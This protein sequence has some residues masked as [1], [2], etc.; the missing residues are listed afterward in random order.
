M[1]IAALF[2]ATTAMV[3]TTFASCSA[4]ESK[5]NAVKTLF[6]VG[7]AKFHDPVELPVILKTYLENNGSYDIDIT[8]DHNEFLPEKIKNYKL[9]IVYTT[10]G[11]LTAEQQMG[12]TEWVKQGNGFIGIHSAT[13]SFKN[14]DEYWKMLGGRFIGHGR[15][16][17]KVRPTFTEHCTTKGIGEFD[18][19]DETYRHEFHPNSKIKVLQRRDLDLE[20]VTW[21]QDYGKGR[22]FVTG[23]GHDKQS[24]ENPSFKNM[25]KQ[26][27]EWA[28]NGDKDTD[29]Q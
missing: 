16:T 2:L 27:A 15:G 26:A 4:N 20:A 19:T 10:G 12:L 11:E 23:L 29:K 24:W 6:M 14:S 1:K 21:V 9:I 3:F 13:D 22:V 28:V 25:M 18:I 8:E 17:F 7:G 5:T